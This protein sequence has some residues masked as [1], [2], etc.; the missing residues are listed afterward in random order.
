[1]RDKEMKVGDYYAV[2]N[3]VPATEMWEI[4]DG[5]RPVSI[6]QEFLDKHIPENRHVEILGFGNCFRA[7]RKWWGGWGVKM[8]FVYVIHKSHE[9]TMLA[10]TAKA[11]SHRVPN[12][13]PSLEQQIAEILGEPVVPQKPVSLAARLTRWLTG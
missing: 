9:G 1:M 6:N 3:H 13:G 8:L 5:D 10:V 12:V 4:L 7:K 2:K 11:F